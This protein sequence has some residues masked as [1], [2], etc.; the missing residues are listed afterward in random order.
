MP[1]Q[2]TVMLRNRPSERRGIVDG[3]EAT[4]Q[5]FRSKV[6]VVDSGCWEWQAGLNQKGYGKFWINGSTRQAHRVGYELMVGA[7]AAELEVHHRCENKKC[8]RPKHLQPMTQREN[9][10]LAGCVEAMTLERTSRT[11]CVRG[12]GFNE[13]NTRITPHGHRVCRA[14]QKIRHLKH[15]EKV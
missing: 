9:E 14:C 11:H 15:Q 2:V 1:C 10:K 6:L 7:V 3:M 8:V 4:L 12:H 5:R 13:T